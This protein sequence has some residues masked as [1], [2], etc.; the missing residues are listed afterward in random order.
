MPMVNYKCGSLLLY[1]VTLA[2]YHNVYVSLCVM[3]DIQCECLQFLTSTK[4]DNCTH[5]HT[6]GYIRNF[7]TGHVC[8]LLYLS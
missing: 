4:I 2:V 7:I 3:Y 8:W 1:I 5:T 6:F